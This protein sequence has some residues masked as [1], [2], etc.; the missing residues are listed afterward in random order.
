MKNKN[1]GLDRPKNFRSLP[2]KRCCGTC[3]HY[4]YYSETQYTT[5]R[6]CYGMD[7]KMGQI[8]FVPSKNEKYYVCDG[9]K[10]IE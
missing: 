5:C 6:R 3:E 9:W 4:I 10:R 2:R 1:D 8:V 7:K